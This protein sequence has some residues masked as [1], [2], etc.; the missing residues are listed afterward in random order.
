MANRLVWAPTILITSSLAQVFYHN[1]TQKNQWEILN[2]WIWF[3][4]KYI[5]I[6][7][8]IPILYYY[9]SDIMIYVLGSKW[10]LT[11]E[12]IFY[13]LFSGIFFIYAIP[14]R[15]AFRATE[16][17]KYLMLLDFVILLFIFSVFVFFS[18]NAINTIKLLTL[19]NFMQSIS[20]IVLMKYILTRKYHV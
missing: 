9:F 2:K 15:V 16:K 7:V 18:L 19:F 11:K 4:Y 17:L 10:Q 6:M 3:S 20:T 1:F 8:T 13:L 12:M 5:A 14:Y